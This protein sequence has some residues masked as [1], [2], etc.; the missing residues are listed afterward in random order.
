MT[1][2][3]K[4]FKYINMLYGENTIVMA[5]KIIDSIDDD[6]AIYKIPIFY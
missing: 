2:S 6:I 5:N 3:E 4:I 1:E